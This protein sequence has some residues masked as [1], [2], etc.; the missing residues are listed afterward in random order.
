MDVNFEWQND[1]AKY[2][3]LDADGAFW[4]YEKKP[5]AR[6][7]SDSRRGYFSTHDGEA[8]KIACIGLKIK[9]WQETL[10]WRK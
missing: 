1:W 7:K 3:A 8:K 4:E 6:L 9:D 5:E 2:R 10:E